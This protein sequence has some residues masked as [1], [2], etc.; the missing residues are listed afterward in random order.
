MNYSKPVMLIFSFILALTFVYFILFGGLGAAALLYVVIYYGLILGYA[1]AFKVKLRLK[2]F[3]LLIPIFL[4]AS[5]FILY[6]NPL[7]KTLNTLFLF[8]LVI[9]QT[10]EMFGASI[11][12]S[13]S[14][15]TLLD[16]M[17]TS[18]L[19]PLCNIGSTFYTLKQFG[20]S[21]EKLKV[22]CK[23]LIGILIAIPFMM[24]VTNLLI[25]SDTAFAEVMY[26]ISSSLTD[27][28][29]MHLVKIGLAMILTL[30]LFAML[31]GVTDNLN[32]LPKKTTLQI[33]PIIDPVISITFSNL[34]GVIY[35]IYC[36]SQL[37]YF[38][39]A[40]QMILPDNFT[41]AEYTR[42]G[43]F[44]LL[45]LSMFNIALIYCLSKLTRFTES[46]VQVKWG[47]VSSI[48]ITLFNLFLIA[49]TLFKMIMYVSSYGLTPLRA[50]TTW[51]IIL[52]GILFLITLAKLFIPKVKAFKCFYISFIILFLVLNYI[53]T[54]KL[55]ARYNISQYTSGV[56]KE[57]DFDLFYSLSDSA[58]PEVVKLLDLNDPSITYEV[59]TFL[60]ERKSNDSESKWENFNFSAYN[61]K[62]IMK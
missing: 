43:F 3:I 1:K 21:K 51:F 40:F 20:G 56:V 31:N 55:I 39:S 7:L 9:L 26:L 59:N 32:F 49:S 50:Y 35:I 6:D 41:F 19:L 38:V 15:N 5:C 24:I 44:E 42:K 52:L 36:F 61:A 53:N 27:E 4:V 58:V 11:Y 28:I 16:L 10:T 48:F 30:F 37:A 33:P 14:L 2:S 25:S 22:L 60:M 57:L 13:F 12:P 62:N 45:P 8:A 23:V 17:H 34:I 18:V 47:H 29:A 46:K 54:D